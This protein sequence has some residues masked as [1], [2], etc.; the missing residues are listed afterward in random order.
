MV[1]G[2]AYSPPTS[3][4]PKSL[5][6][7]QYTREAEEKSPPPPASE[8]WT[9]RSTLH[10]QKPSFAENS[11]QHKTSVHP[12]QVPTPNGMGASSCTPAFLDR[13]FNRLICNLGWQHPHSQLHLWAPPVPAALLVAEGPMAW[14]VPPGSGPF[15]PQD[16]A[17]AQERY[18]QA[19]NR[20]W[21]GWRLAPSCL[22]H[23]DPGL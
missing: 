16:K 15:P 7:T 1:L 5:L 22:L 4:Q 2:R 17:Q 13:H 3:Q 18:L 10:P 23:P 12:G 20:S 14:A 8:S 19:W 6:S 9:R 21:R 11:I